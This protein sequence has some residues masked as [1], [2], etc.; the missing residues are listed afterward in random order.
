M[1]LATY[2]FENYANKGFAPSVPNLKTLL[3]SLLQ[4]IPATRICIDGLDK[5]P[6]P[7][8]RLILTQLLELTE[9]PNIPCKVLF[10]SRDVENIRRALQN[11]PTINFRDEKGAVESD[12]K[13]YVHDAIGELR[14]MRDEFR[15][16]PQVL[17]DIEKQVIAKANGKLSSILLG[18]LIKWW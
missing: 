11:K 5:Y 1:E 13:A 6:P 4:T 16:H 2:V 10:S 8:Q 7:D 3:K 9:L 15:S 12:I 17:D 18:Q 14:E